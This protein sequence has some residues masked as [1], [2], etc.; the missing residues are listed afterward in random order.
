MACSTDT[1]A[2]FVHCGA[3]IMKPISYK[4]S[5]RV[6]KARRARSFSTGVTKSIIFISLVLVVS[7]V[8]LFYTPLRPLTMLSGI[9][10]L[11]LMFGLWIRWDLSQTEAVYNPDSAEIALNDV[12]SSDIV[13]LLDDKQSPQ[14]VLSSI[15]NNWQAGFILVRYQIPANA[16][17]QSLSNDPAKSVELWN[18]AFGLV[19]DM[20]VKQL[21]AG[22]IVVAMI[23]NNPVML[24]WLRKNG[25]DQSDIMGGLNWLESLWRRNIRPKQENLYGG[26]GRDW[27]SGYTPF[28]DHFGSNISLGIAEN[29]LDFSGVSRG[30]VLEQIQTDLIKNDRN[31]VAM[32]GEVGVGKSALVYALAEKLIE[33]VDVSP[34]LSYKQVVQIDPA[35]VSAAVSESLSL[36]QI[37][38]EIINNAVRAQ[39]IIL[40]LD[41]ASL[42][43]GSGPGQ[44]NLASILLPA[45]QSKGLVVIASFNLE[46]WQKLSTSS[47]ALAALF[48]KVEV[49]AADRDQT[50]AILQDMAV[51]LEARAKAPATI[52]YK[53]IQS[54]YELSDRYLRSKA[55]PA[56]AIDLLS[57]SLNYSSNGL[58]TPESVAQ[59]TEIIT[60]TKVSEASAEEK[61]QLL[62]LEE[63]IHARMINQSRAVKVVSDALRRSRA[64][65][66]NTHRPVG[67]FLF[68][69][70][71]GVGKTELSK[72]LAAV[73]FGN[74]DSMNRLDMSEY[75]NKSDIKRLLQSASSESVG[76]TFLQKINQNPFSVVLLDEIEK[77]HPDILNLLLQML[78]EG[79]LTDSAGHKISFKEAIIIC[80]SN[81]GANEIRQK[82]TEGKKL[83]EFASDFTNDLINKNIFKPELI[84]RFDEIVLF[85]PLDKPE[86]L[87][88]AKLIIAQV[89]KELEDRKISVEL[90]DQALEKLVNMGYDPR[91]GARPMRRVISRTVENLLATKVLSGEIEPGAVVKLDANDLQEVS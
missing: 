38:T 85:R 45:L 2:I 72:S 54:A 14:Q 86:L 25:M 65:V 44:V 41:E 37:F 77:A 82:I 19:A 91:L 47:P 34:E 57:D 30:H 24:D 17:M 58:V 5:I 89:N 51:Q 79:T 42:F 67:S 48:N 11:G 33:G 61:T 81:A 22:I 13:Y 20:P 3:C 50:I 88:V 90:T 23:V 36:E 16:L 69:G 55:M 84:N 49:E 66:R 43:F 28:L 32:V 35:A 68:L 8:V 73:Y 21:S 59:A 60:N 7:G 9:G 87:Q 46:E 26:I 74:E 27:T 1:G 53:A 75:Q 76:S 52:T 64:G 6:Q 70:P 71:T 18:Q 31:N 78:D 39:N 12:L 62:N 63:L 29:N 80:T 15:I 10:I 56:K 40:Y 4:N 83:E